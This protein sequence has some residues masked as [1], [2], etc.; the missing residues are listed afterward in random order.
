MILIAA[1][2]PFSICTI[3]FLDEFFMNLLLYG[4][5]RFGIYC[6]LFRITAMILIIF[7]SSTYDLN[8]CYYCLVVVVLF[9]KYDEPKTIENIMN[10][11]WGVFLRARG[12]G[13]HRWCLRMH[14][15]ES[16]L[17]DG[18][19]CSMSSELQSEDAETTHHLDS[20]ETKELQCN[21]S[22]ARFIA[23][24]TMKSHVVSMHNDVTYTRFQCDIC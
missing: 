16:V 18:S 3:L 19:V 12:R 14:E 22:S 17:E 6:R 10:Y 24:T 20:L 1:E 4:Q 8:S 9:I 2:V 13:T 23:L 15:C 21:Y 11:L 7:G 5:I